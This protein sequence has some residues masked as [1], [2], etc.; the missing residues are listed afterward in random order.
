MK[1]LLLLAVIHLLIFHQYE[2]DKSE[3]LAPKKD[4]KPVEAI[5]QADKGYRF[6]VRL[7]KSNETSDS[8]HNSVQSVPLK[9]T[10]AVYFSPAIP[11]ILK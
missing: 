3:A 11:A 7:T 6:P 4:I 10:H 5:I 9:P 8:L 1:Q 2:K